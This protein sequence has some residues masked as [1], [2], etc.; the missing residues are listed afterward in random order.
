MAG[1]GGGGAPGL[2][3]RPDLLGPGRAR[4]R[5][6]RRPA[7]PSSAWP[8]PPTGPTGPG[9]C[10]PAT[11]RGTGSSPPCTGPATPPS[12]PASSRDDGLACATCYITAS[13]HCAP[14][15][16]KP[17]PER[18]GRLRALSCPRAGPAED[19]RVIVVLG[20]FACQSVAGL[21]GLR[22]RP[23]FGHLAEYAAAR[24]AHA[25]VLV[26]PEPAEHLHRGADRAHV[27]RRVRP[28]P[29]DRRPG[30]GVPVA[31]APGGDAP[32]SRQRESIDSPIGGQSWS[33]ARILSPTE[34]GR[35]PWTS[36]LKWT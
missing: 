9:A 30:D 7:W 24:R 16:N 21:L 32:E 11:D 18:A 26:S 5:R 34:T 3:R 6:R 25:P 4:I 10:S 31:A 1:A 29:P 15:A 28:G 27:R 12:P 35:S 19:V 20:Q 33:E 22:P 14:P 8:R 17:E 23:K 13:V 36:P 2:L